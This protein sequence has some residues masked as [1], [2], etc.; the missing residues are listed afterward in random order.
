MVSV[1]SSKEEKHITW[2]KVLSH[3]S[4]IENHLEELYSTKKNRRV[5]DIENEDAE[6]SATKSVLKLYEN[7]TKFLKYCNIRA[8]T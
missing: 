2:V 5:K 4:D 3:I 7:L 1:Q 6:K 8:L